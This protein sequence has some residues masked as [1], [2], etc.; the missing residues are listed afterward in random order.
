MMREQLFQRLPRL[1]RIVGE[2]DA[3]GQ[4]PFY[5]RVRIDAIG[6]ERD[7]N[8]ESDVDRSLEVD[9]PAHGLR[10]DKLTIGVMTNLFTHGRAR[11]WCHGEA[12]GH[13]F[14]AFLEDNFAVLNADY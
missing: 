13:R 12:R 9:H 3:E 8:A 2:A 7:L 1:V 14:A 6:T 11:I 4:Q 5:R 10:H